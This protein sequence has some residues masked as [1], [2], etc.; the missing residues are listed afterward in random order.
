MK[1]KNGMGIAS[2]VCAIIGLCLWIAPYIALPLSI[3][4]V[5]FASKQNKIEPTGKAT[6]GMVM[7]IIGIVINAVMLLFVLLV[8]IG[9]T[10]Y[11]L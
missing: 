5:V 2:L 11:G 3:L 9:M 7:G 8:Y 10:A 6:A 4:A 1:E